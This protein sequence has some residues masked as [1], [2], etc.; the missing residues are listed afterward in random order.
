M[1]RFQDIAREVLDKAMGRSA[2]SIPDIKSGE[3]SIGITT[4]EHRFD[5][6]FTPLLARIRKFAQNEIVV[7]VNGEHEREF[8]DEYRSRV[9]ECIA[10]HRNSYPIVFPRFRGLSKL[11][12]SVIVHATCDYILM[13]N[14]DVMIERPDFMDSVCSALRRNAGRTFLIN[15]SWSHFV[16]SR[17]EIDEL[18]YFDERLLGI[19]EEDGDIVW[20]YLHRHGREIPSFILKGFV[21]FA[22]E[23]VRTYKPVNIQTHS[24]TKYSLFNRNFMF[25]EKYQPSP[26]GIKGMFDEPVVLKDPGK[27]QYPNERFYR[28][29]KKDL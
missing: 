8:G 28:F 5:K 22:E 24:G 29:R 15:R 6:Y 18:G 1:K 23:S 27:E 17:A 16:V 26:D 13:L 4:F 12:N 3:I 25:T 21:N 20:R 7:A 2:E 14:D 10:R 19:G 9:L 11:W